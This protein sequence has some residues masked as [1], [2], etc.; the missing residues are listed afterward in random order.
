MEFELESGGK[1]HQ[2]TVERTE[3]GYRVH[4]GGRSVEC[5]CRL[6]S[7]TSRL[8]LKGQMPILVHLVKVDRAYH[9]FVAGETFLVTRPLSASRQ[10]ATRQEAASRN[11]EICAPMPGRLL[12]VLAREG[13][14]VAPG[15]RL[16]IVEAMKMEHEVRSPVA[17]VIRKVNFREDA[18]VAPGQPLVEIDVDDSTFGEAPLSGEDLEKR[19]GRT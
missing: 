6:V 10:E 14:R 17:G 3:N 15:D 12:K 8:L 2:L 16:A 18:L 5:Q 9:V 11:G 19:E 4:T 1:R 7:P 13:Q